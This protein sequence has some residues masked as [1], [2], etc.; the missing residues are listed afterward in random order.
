MASTSWTMRDCSSALSYAK[1][2]AGPHEDRRKMR[3]RTA[4]YRGMAFP[5]AMSRDIG[6]FCEASL[7]LAE[8][9]LDAFVSH[10][11][12]D[13]ADTISSNPSLWSSLLFRRL[14]QPNRKSD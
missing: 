12:W 5:S 2:V 6:I 11:A 3:L 9:V 1:G 10:T 8:I 7:S 14:K 13:L 4:A